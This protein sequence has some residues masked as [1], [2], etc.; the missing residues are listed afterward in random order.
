MRTPS[1]SK[2]T[3]PVSS[4]GEVNGPFPNNLRVVDG[5]KTKKFLYWNK[6]DCCSIIIFK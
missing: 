1:Y 4:K 6:S 3:S 5:Q 2:K